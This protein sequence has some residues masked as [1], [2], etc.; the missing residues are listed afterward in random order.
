MQKGKDMNI[1]KI[2]NKYILILICGVSPFLL[3]AN[4][5]Y[6]IDV[7]LEPAKRTV[8]GHLQMSFYNST[9]DTLQEL[10]VHLW[11]NAYSG[12]HTPWAKQMV[13]LGQLD[14][15]Y[16]KS[17]G[18]IDSLNF[19]VDGRALTL[20]TSDDQPDVGVILL[21]QPL[22]PGKSITLNTP[23]R[24]KLPEMTSRSGYTGSFYSLTQWYPKFAV[25]QGGEW[26]SMSYLEQGEFFSDFADY[27]VKVTLPSV[28]GFAATGYQYK[29]VDTTES[30]ITYEVNQSEIHDFAWFASRKFIV[31]QKE[32]TLKSGKKVTLQ[33]YVHNEAIAD[34]ILHYAS[35]TVQYMSENVGEYPY[36]VCTVVEGV[37]G[38]GN[39]MEYPTIC[40]IEGGATLKVEVVHEVIH[41]WWYGILA[42]NERKEPFL[43]ESLTSYYEHRVIARLAENESSWIEEHKGVAKYFGLNRLPEKPME[44]NVL[45]QQY[46]TNLQQPD[47][48]T[49][50]EYSGANYY[51]MMYAKGAF[52]IKNLEGYLGREAFDQLMQV[53]YEKNKFQHISIAGLQQHFKEECDK[54]TEWFFEGI[55]KSSE[56][57]DLSVKGI[58]KENARLNVTL[59]NKKSLKTATEVALVDKDLNVL[60]SVWVED[61]ENEKQ[62]S[63]S[64]HKDAYAVLVDPQWLTPESNRRNNF[65]KVNGIRSWK[66]AQVRLLGSLEDPTKNQL[67]LTPVLAG[68]KYDG[69]M[70]G[71][72]L[73][74]R[75]FP[76]KK[77]EYELVPLFAFK[78]K[79]FN[80]I[81]NVSY[82]ISPKKQK[83]IDIE[84]GLHSKSF[85]INN[86]PIDLKF[87]K[88]QPFMEATF[89]K[90][91]NDNGPIH[92]VGYRNIH[93]WQ[94]AYAAQRD[95][96]T[97]DVS[98]S[99]VKGHFNT[100]EFWYSL[101]NLHSIYPHELKTVVRFDKDYV[102]QSVEFR[103]KFRYTRKGSFVHM[104]FFAGAF[105]YRNED[106]SFRRNAVVGF[107]MSGINGKNDYLYD[108]SYF[109]RNAQEGFASRQMMMGEGNFKVFTPLQN[110]PEG[111]TVNGLFAANFK[112]DAPVKW[113]PVQL[114]LDMGYSIDKVLMPDNLLPVKQFHYDMGFCISLMDEAIE[115]YFP[116]LM[117]DNFR[118][119]YKSNLP[120][121]GQRITFAINMDKLNF[122]KGIRENLLEKVMK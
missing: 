115:V 55:L 33:A 108:G 77:L 92:K 100:S 93:I 87:I 86:R 76:V 75:V 9:N 15:R 8:K 109:G 20:M 85:S 2:V 5:K 112:L 107:N 32:I 44:K 110:I 117:S 118:T 66:P 24:V 18:K 13:Q 63:F 42:N 106:I 50:E 116:L 104:R 6:N 54:D 14:F 41:N 69:F 51:A 27:Q 22:L 64:D 96:I 26:Q 70:L 21:N 58:R 72:A 98:F 19:T 114:F 61:F 91:S 88:L 71:L 49:S 52:D 80:W 97:G 119:Y 79:Q 60:E 113:L 94:D 35:E 11:P 45:L 12:H 89:R 82:H 7:E 78:S 84:I 111:K 38:I 81:G 120:K 47:N 83:P 1:V 25:Y 48:L 4:N 65:A 16:G 105:Y 59:K 30:K 122:H 103:Q 68:N 3:S 23:F 34:D 10:W 56:V 74:N 90:L 121:F 57:S 40:N 102:R 37:A 46:R 28:Y 95:S 17:L 39:G 29:P 101:Q 73:Y 53:F 99:K 43:D 62:I 67:F 31:K 36:D